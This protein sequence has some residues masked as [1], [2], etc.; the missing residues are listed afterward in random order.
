MVALACAALL[1]L[2]ACS[3]DDDSDASPGTT[4]TPQTTAPATGSELRVGALL[5][6]TGPGSSLGTNSRAALEL[7]TQEW[8]DH[9]ASEGSDVEVVLDVEDTELDPDKAVA[10]LEDLAD[11]GATIVIGPQSSAELAAI[12]D[13][14]TDR[15]VLVISQGSTASSLS[16]ISPNIFRYVPNDRVEGQ[17]TADLMAQDGVRSVVPVWRD[18]AGNEGLVTSVSAAVSAAGGTVAT[19]VRYE[20]ATSDFG[21]VV[22][23]L[24]TQLDAATGQDDPDTVG[25][26]LAGFEETADLLAAA[27]DAGLPAVRWYGGDG[28]A[29]SAQLLDGPGA[30]FAAAAGG[31]P[32]PLVALPPDQAAQNAELVTQVEALGGDQP[33][34]FAL[35][36]YDAFNVAVQAALDL[37]PDADIDTLRTSFVELSDHSVGATGPIQLDAGGDRTSAPYA[38][39]SICD[40]GGTTSWVRTGLWTPGAA[41][42]EPGTITAGSCA[43]PI[44]E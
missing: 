26:Y 5:A 32:S 4:A 15:G 44:P 39:W 7:A 23:E 8:N 42:G 33:D 36:A 41:P 12:A 25:V 16:G 34:A 17:A 13:V 18:D 11:R 28:S 1:V 37:G 27:A 2:A 6:T 40:E 22:A 31:Y 3:S 38:F 24:A 35:A 10:A 19:G 9:L 30:A 20:P 43:S 29:Q 21:P 14:A